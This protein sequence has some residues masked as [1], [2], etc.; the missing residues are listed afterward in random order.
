MYEDLSLRLR[1]QAARLPNKF[2]ENDELFQL[3]T[4]AAEA[5]DKAASLTARLMSAAE[6]AEANHGREFSELFREAARTIEDLQAKNRASY[7][8]GRRAAFLEIL[9]QM[10][11]E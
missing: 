11:R 3:L 7:L 10:P 8:D 4:D 6:I 1:Y 2:S 5:L 9:G